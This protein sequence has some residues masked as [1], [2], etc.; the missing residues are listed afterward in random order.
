MNSEGDTQAKIYLDSF[1]QSEIESALQKRDEAILKE[2]E[3]KA[4]IGISNKP[5]FIIKLKDLENI[6]KS[7]L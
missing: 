1:I 4:H 6:I 7:K 5:E 3:K 2:A